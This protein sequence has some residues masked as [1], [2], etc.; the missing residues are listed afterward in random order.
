MYSYQVC[1][2]RTIKTADG[3][4][5]VRQLPTFQVQASSDR[6]AEAKARDIVGA[7][8]HPTSVCVVQLV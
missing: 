2:T 6:E 1:A 3:W 8:L 5:S 4:H 7:S